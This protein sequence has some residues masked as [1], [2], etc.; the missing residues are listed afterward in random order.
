MSEPIELL[1]G[2]HESDEQYN[3]AVITAGTELGRV[4]LL[5]EKTR[6]YGAGQLVLPGGKERYYVGSSGMLLVPGGVEREVREE[7]K[8]AVPAGG[9]TPAGGLVVS[10]DEDILRQINVYT[11]ELPGPSTVTDSDEQY[12]LAWFPAHDLPYD[13][14]PEDYEMW[15]R[16]VLAG[17]A[18]FFFLRHEGG[19]LVEVTGH[20]GRIG[21]DMPWQTFDTTITGLGEPP[22]PGQNPNA[23]H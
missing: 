12:N 16:H 18:I 22:T 23:G 5:G 21:G 13:R 19:K 17:F 1:G 4:V 9:W 20:G 8:L 2:P 10:D 6:G 7:T 14:M 15:L 11:T 3:L